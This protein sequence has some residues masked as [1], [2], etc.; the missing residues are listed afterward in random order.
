[1]AVI[2]YGDKDLIRCFN[3]LPRQ[4]QKSSCDKGLQAAGGVF[5]TAATAEV[6]TEDLV[7]TGMLRDSMVVKR[8]R[9]RSRDKLYATVGARHRA[10]YVRLTRPKRSGNG[11]QA[12][13]ADRLTKKQAIK[14][15]QAFMSGEKLKKVNPGRYAHLVEFG[16]RIA[17]SKGG[18]VKPHPF[19]RPAFDKSK[20]LATSAFKSKF[21]K[22]LVLDLQKYKFKRGI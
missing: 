6:E 17:G 7:L 9:P 22:Y 10:Y 8:R 12:I 21:R 15:G 3:N 4:V 5:K 14:A 13:P 2:V 20:F 11:F 1:M 18:M 16:H 19:M